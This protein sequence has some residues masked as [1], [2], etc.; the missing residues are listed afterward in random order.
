MFAWWKKLRSKSTAN[1]DRRDLVRY[2]PH[3]EGLEARELP[4][5][6]LKIVNPV[7]NV[8]QANGNQ[9]EQ[10]I[11]VNPLNPNQVVAFS[12]VEDLD[13]DFQAD[14]GLFF[15]WSN[16]GG[17]TWNQSF[18]FT[19]DTLLDVA[20][21][22]PQVAWDT[23][24]NAWL[25]YLT[26]NFDIALAL[27]VDGGRT[28]N[29]SILTT[30]G[31]ADQ[32]SLAVGPGSKPGTGAVWVTYNIDSPTP[33]QQIQGALVTARGAW[34]FFGGPRD[35]PGS[36]LVNGQFGDIVVGPRGEVAVTYQSLGGPG[37]GPSLLYVN[38]DPDGLGPKPMGPRILVTSTNVGGARIIPGTGNNL[39]IDAEVNLAW[40][41]SNGPHRGRLYMVYTDAP[42]TATID[43]NVFIRYSDNRGKTW[44]PRVL[45]HD[46]T[47]GSQFNP[48]I[49]VDQF[50]GLVAVAW[51]D[52]RNDPSG[53]QAEFFVT[54]SDNG[55][56]SFGKDLVVSLGPSTSV[57]AEV[58]PVVAGL[59]PLGFGDYNKI[60]FVRGM[61]QLVWAD[62]SPQLP[63]NPSPGRMEIAAAR[64]R[65][66]SNR[67]QT[68]KVSTIFRNDFKLVSRGGALYDGTITIINRSK[69]RVLGPLRFQI[70]LPHRSMQLRSQGAE[71]VGSTWVFT[72]N[73][74]LPASGAIS[75]KVQIFN[76]FRLRIEGFVG[77]GFVTSLR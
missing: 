48:A 67:I 42:D 9:R 43:T 12:N 65:V 1:R 6:S 60:D 21:C 76:P 55:G 4:A 28:F 57:L 22:D 72:T 53:I 50:T 58:P 23:F 7:V 3:V 62:N 2:R 25:T 49:A 44:S 30:T 52:T 34:S 17:K 11:A 73:K 61:I 41:R 69:Q 54:A 35:V 14:P 15:G 8:S 20:C 75:F 39:G 10:S 26:D 38:I 63:G 19:D 45:V 27:S 5:V 68:R 64:V 32:P 13:F 16:D 18:I 74:N 70:Q 37:A 51:Y 66:A 59:R 46:V 29:A 77:T 47:A 71:Q 31:D 24:G 33:R 40:D 36:E 56:R